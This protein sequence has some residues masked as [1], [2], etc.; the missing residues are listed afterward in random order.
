MPDIKS[1]IESIK[2]R[3]EAACNRVN[4]EPKEVTLLAATKDVPVNLIEEAIQAGII[5]IGENRVQ[6]AAGKFELLKGKYPQV[7]WHMIG[8]LQT[9]KIGQAL[10]IFDIIQSVDSVRLAEEINKR[11]EVLGK[12]PALPA[13]RCEVFIEVNVSGEESKSGVPFSLAEELVIYISGSGNLS[14]TG[15]MTVPPYFDEQE[16]A[17]PYFRKLSQLRDK[18]KGLNLPNVDLKYLS[19]GMTDDF[20]AAIEEGSNIVRIGR[21]IFGIEHKMT[22]G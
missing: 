10:K 9:N 2:R 19:M 7:T 13:G 1:N 22:G 18:I 3:I 8:H 12:R 11:Y 20:E 16:K 5:H 6:E 4:R 17:T 21:G 14:V 15:L